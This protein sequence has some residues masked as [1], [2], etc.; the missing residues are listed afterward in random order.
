ML[1]S[2]WKSSTWELVGLLNFSSLKVENTRRARE[3][4]VLDFSTKFGI[5]PGTTLYRRAKLDQARERIA[6]V[7]TNLPLTN[8]ARMSL[9]LLD[10]PFCIFLL[11]VGRWI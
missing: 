4:W 6:R 11:L 5:I 8:L 3:V 10:Q 7:R 9:T 2:C 1:Y